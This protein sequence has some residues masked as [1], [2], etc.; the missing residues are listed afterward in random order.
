[1]TAFNWTVT[2][3]AFD[4]SQ[5]AVFFFAM[6]P[7][8]NLDDKAMISHYFNLTGA[9]TSTSSASGTIVSSTNATASFL[10]TP[11]TRT[12]TSSPI[13]NQ[14][15][16]GSDNMLKLGLG[17]GL[18]IPLLIV[19]TVLVSLLFRRNRSKKASHHADIQ[20]PP[21]SDQEIVWNHGFYNLQRH[22]IDGADI[23]VPGKSWNSAPL[24]HHQT[25]PVE[26]YSSTHDV[27]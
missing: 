8:S 23:Y 11:S 15:Q 25:V 4:L 14:S 17:L 13:F 16:G 5:S 24:K 2:S 1:M 6:G 3:Q 19:L 22:E 10:S 12:P 27:R 26:I 18:G 20:K 9:A 7:T 21:I